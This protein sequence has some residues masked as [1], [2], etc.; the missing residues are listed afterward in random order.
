MNTDPATPLGHGESKIMLVMADC[1]LNKSGV[2]LEEG[3]R[4]KFEVVNVELWKDGR[5]I[6]NPEGFSRWWLKPF[7]KFRRYPEAAL[8]TLV[9]GVTNVLRHW[10][11]IVQKATQVASA[12]GEFFCFANDVGFRYGN[13]KGQLL[14][15]ITHL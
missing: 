1:K 13:N 15:K 10:F 2:I 6:T 3:E 9:G 8:L 11:Q 12:E 4:Y 14:L 7:E 5:I